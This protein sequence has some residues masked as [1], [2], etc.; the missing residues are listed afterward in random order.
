V[1]LLDASLSGLILDHDLVT[2]T[3]WTYSLFDY[4]N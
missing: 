3:L 4:F 2:A 1:R